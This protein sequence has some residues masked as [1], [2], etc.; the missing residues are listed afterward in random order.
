[1]KVCPVCKSTLFDDMD[2]CYGCMYRF[3]GGEEGRL[4]EQSP[5]AAANLYAAAL[6]GAQM[7][8]ESVLSGG[9]TPAPP[10]VA[11]VRREG[12]R[13][14]SGD[15]GVP[16]FLVRIEVRD[17]CEEGRVW[18]VELTPRVSCARAAGG[19]ARFGRN[20]GSAPCAG[21]LLEVDGE[22]DLFSD[23]E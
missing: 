2:V 8:R 3:D 16:D 12:D 11:G 22:Q 5:S 20:E 6:A 18:A 21:A 15:A 23:V 10:D 19:D 9:A 4:A 7:A 17:L 1:M 13:A 14:G